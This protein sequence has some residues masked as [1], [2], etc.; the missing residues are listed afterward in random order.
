VTDFS[1][2]RF[3]SSIFLFIIS[4]IL[5]LFTIP[6]QSQQLSGSSLTAKGTT[7]PYQ[8]AASSQ[9]AEFEKNAQAQG[10]SPEEIELYK[11]KYSSQQN[12]STAPYPTHLTEF[13]KQVRPEDSLQATNDSTL[14]NYSSF[15]DTLQ[16]DTSDTAHQGDGLPFFGYN[17]FKRIPDAFK[18]N[19]IGPIDPGYLAGP[20]DVL[21]LSVWGEVEFQYELKVDREGKIF[22]PVAGQIYVTGIPFEKLQKKIQ[23]ILSKHY[24]GLASTPQ[25]SFLDLSI[26]QIHP[27][28]I[29]MMGEVKSPGGYTVSTSSTAFNAFYSIG[30]PL[31]S[32][33]L[34]D[35][36]IIRDQKEIAQLDLYD[37]LTTGK[38]STDVRLLNDDVVFTP[39]RGKSVAITGAVFRPAIY[40]LKESEKLLTLLSYCGGILPQSNGSTAL[41]IRV[42]PIQERDGE[43]PV[44]KVLDVDLQ[45]LLNDSVDV[46]LCDDDTIKIAPLSADLKNYAIISGAVHYPGRYQVENLSLYTLIFSLGKPIETEAFTAR[47]DLIRPNEDKVTFS[48]I[49]INLEDLYTDSAAHDQQLQPLDEVIVYKKEVEKP[50][51]LLITVDGE[52]RNPGSY[53]LSTNQTIYDALLRAGGFTREAHK[54]SIDIYRL[55]LSRNGSD[56][57]TETFNITLPDTIDFNSP[58]E[59]QFKL[60]DRD[61]IVVR[62]NADYITDNYVTIEGL[63]KFRGKYAIR[64]RGER[65]SD[66]ISRAGGLLPDAFLEGA[67]VTRNKQRVVVDFAEAL[68]GKSSKENILL[69]KNDIISI[70]PRPNTVLVSGNVNNPGLFSYVENSKVRTYIDRAGGLADSSTYILLTSPGGETQKVRKISFNNPLVKDGSTI[71]VM[72]KLPRDPANER[73][74]P[75]V[76]EVIRDTLAIMAS[77]FT[78]IGLAIQIR[79]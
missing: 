17:I 2:S 64:V 47:A 29:F 53:T 56:T 3:R 11:K 74:G 19:A 13:T 61:K 22:I 65:L 18:P 23:L 24:S 16:T 51:D 4:S 66:L 49:P 45:K 67:T 34:R 52:V 77:A 69:Q 37:Y 35:I 62:P 41:I 10:Y 6:A 43:K 14:Q 1:R 42:Q 28:R 48:T 70:P 15:D 71:F 25:K 32:G 8:T 59:D 30:G 76:T 38:C 50:I 46:E 78:V 33:S 75:T 73:R 36:H 55:H 57:I 68:T 31:N 79:K 20:G 27:I 40:E 58:R 39:K 9:I 5:I 7:N 72:K 63:V 44:R 21:R 54:K 26:A 12:S 60:N